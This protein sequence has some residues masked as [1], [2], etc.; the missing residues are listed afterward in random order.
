[1]VCNDVWYKAAACAR[2]PL[3]LILLLHKLKMSELKIV[4]YTLH[5]FGCVNQSRCS[6]CSNG[7]VS[8]SN[9]INTAQYLHKKHA[10]THTMCSI[11]VVVV[12]VILGVAGAVV[13]DS[14]LI[15]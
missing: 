11:V 7:S 9:S 13:F 6:E 14:S 12:V 3:A 15:Y 2:F 5:I 1:M 10:H 8:V 4:L